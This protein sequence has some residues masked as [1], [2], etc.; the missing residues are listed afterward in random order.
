MGTF[1]AKDNNQ[2]I[3]HP[4]I[5]YDSPDENFLASRFTVTG[6]NIRV[7][8]SSDFVLATKA[9]LACY[10]VFN[11]AYPKA[12]NGGLTFIQKILGNVQDGAPHIPKLNTF[13]GLVYT[14]S[15]GNNNSKENSNNINN[16]NNNK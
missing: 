7:A 2:A 6:D 14:F 15:Q 12:A 5:L 4:I 10:Y 3:N 9:L 11:I 8:V 1:V 16:N 13:M